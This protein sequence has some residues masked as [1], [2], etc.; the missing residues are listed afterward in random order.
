MEDEAAAQLPL[1]RNTL[2]EPIR[3]GLPIQPKRLLTP[4]LTISVD[5]VAGALALSLMS[6]RVRHRDSLNELALRT[7]F[8]RRKNNVP[9]I[10]RPLVRRQVYLVPM[11]TSIENPLDPCTIRD[12]MADRNSSVA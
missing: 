6:C 3:L 12:L 10:G 8:A 7:I 9:M 11:Q 1:S 4:F 5:T 2:V